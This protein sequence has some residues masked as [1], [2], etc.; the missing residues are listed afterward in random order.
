MAVV[1]IAT[2]VLTTV[3]SS[4][5]RVTASATDPVRGA[6]DTYAASLL[7]DAMQ[8][9]KYASPGTE[10]SGS[11]ATAIPVAPHSTSLP[12]TVFAR[13]TSASAQQARIDIT[14]RS[15]GYSAAAGG[16]VFVKAPVPNARIDRPGFVPA[17][18]A[19]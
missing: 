7:R 19:P 14:V 1:A 11:F 18:A 15:A 12:V 10:P 6:V 5:S 8:A 9:W 4:G 17:P 3:L 2:L 16:T 13:V